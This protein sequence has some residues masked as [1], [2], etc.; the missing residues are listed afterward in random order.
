MLRGIFRPTRLYFSSTVAAVCTF[1]ASG[2]F[3]EWLISI[4]FFVHES[5]KDE[6]GNCESCYKPAYGRQIMFFL[7]FGILLNIEYFV[8][9]YFPKIH[10]FLQKLPRLVIVILVLMT[11]VPIGHWFF[12][13]MV[14]G[15]YFHQCQ[16]SLPIVVLM[17]KTN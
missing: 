1:I 16:I 17:R 10:H 11:G 7:W 13:D 8:V 6:N 14:K 15:K 2:L 12:G 3:H 5:D 4:I 9:K